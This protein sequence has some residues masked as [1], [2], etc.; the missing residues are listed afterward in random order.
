MKHNETLVEFE[1]K[2]NPSLSDDLSAN[3]NPFT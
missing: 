3:D 1:K 2:L